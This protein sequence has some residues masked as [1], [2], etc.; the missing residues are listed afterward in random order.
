M[1]EMKPIKFEELNIEQKLGMSMCALLGSNAES[2]EFAYELIRRRSLGAVWINPSEQSPAYMQKVKEIADYPIL[3]I[4]DGEN[5][6]ADLKVGS[7][8]AIGI[9]DSEEL[10]Y[11]FGKSV[12]VNARNAGYNVVCNPVV[13]M[14]FGNCQCGMN[15]RCIGN[16]KEKVARLAAAEIRGMHDG[17]LLSVCKH[18]PGQSSKEPCGD[19]HMAETCVT[20]SLEDIMNVN[21]YPYKYLIDRGL[22]DGIM[23][24]H[25]RFTSV[26]DVYPASLSKKCIDLI[27]NLGFDGFAITDALSMMGVVAKYGWEKSKAMAVGAGNDLALVWGDTQRSY[28]AICKGYDEG[29]ITDDVLDAIVK[30]VINSQNKTMAQPKYTSLTEEEKKD[31]ERLNTDTIFAKVDEGIIPAISK[32]ARHYFVILT[33]MDAEIDGEGKITVDTFSKTFFKPL[34]IAEKL[35]E[36]FPNSE[37]FAIKQFPTPGENMKVLERNTAYDDVVFITF[38]SAAAYVGEE[39]F[40]SRI[41]SLMNSLQVTSRISAVVHFGNP[42]PIEALPHIPRILIGTRSEKNV[43]A[44]LEVLAG[45]REA[46]GVLTYEVNLK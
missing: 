7:H 38:T 32:D 37:F 39:C 21:L 9:S 3:I 29:L 5:G 2:N 34:K 6:F 36:L 11:I 33:E 20:D 10:A 43:E 27:R 42:Y 40:T 14:A 26:D 24:T 18:Y 4:C 8:N 44:A 45:E 28:N 15:T 25:C 30:R 41:V 17:G 22:L 19:S 16:D 13:D 35:K 12:A 46:K 31:F 23:T 1:K